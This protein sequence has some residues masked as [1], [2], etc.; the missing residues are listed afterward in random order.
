MLYQKLF[1]PGEETQQWLGFEAFGKWYVLVRS[2]VGVYMPLACVTVY[3][4]DALTSFDEGEIERAG[5]FT[6]QNVNEEI[7][8]NA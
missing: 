5:Q 4:E 7:R 2:L 6:E 8:S 3:P 1:N